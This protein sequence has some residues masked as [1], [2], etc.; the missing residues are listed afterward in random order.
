MSILDGK[1]KKIEFVKTK[2]S[3][4]PVHTAKVVG[5]ATVDVGG[6]MDNMLL[7]RSCPLCQVGNIDP[8]YKDAVF[9]EN[10]MKKLRE[11]VRSH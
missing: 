6:L 7:V 8:E 9:C 10:C 3:T 2:Q 4:N 11:Y 5:T 1:P